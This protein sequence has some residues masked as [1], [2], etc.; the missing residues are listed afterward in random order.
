MWAC[1]V[2]GYAFDQWLSVK[3]LELWASHVES[4][5]TLKDAEEKLGN[6]CP[7]AKIEI[8]YYEVC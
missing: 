8:E 5:K 6:L 2:T 1:T 3:Y 4:Q 7:R